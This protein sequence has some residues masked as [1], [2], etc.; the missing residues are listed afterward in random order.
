ML[1]IWTGHKIGR[2][3]ESRQC[4]VIPMIIK[5]KFVTD[6]HFLQ[7]FVCKTISHGYIITHFDFPIS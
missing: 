2:L 1:S 5:W 3:V 6:M 4:P 7:V